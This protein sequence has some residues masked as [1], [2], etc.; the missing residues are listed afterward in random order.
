MVNVESPHEVR[1]R[2]SIVKSCALTSCASSAQK[3]WESVAFKVG[4]PEMLQKY[5]S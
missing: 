2:L 1:V 3:C 4:C 5:F